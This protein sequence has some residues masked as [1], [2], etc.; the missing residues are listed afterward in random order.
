MDDSLKK[1]CGYIK[2]PEAH[3]EA[4]K[5]AVEIIMN[6]LGRHSKFPISS[7]IVG[8][9]LEAGENTSTC[10]KADVDV[11][12][13]VTWSLNDVRKVCACIKF[14]IK[15]IIRLRGGG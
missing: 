14:P 9:G 12:V 1:F 11:T 13:F 6:L 2:P 10:L 15:I 8:G 4:C 7:Y 3:N 5:A